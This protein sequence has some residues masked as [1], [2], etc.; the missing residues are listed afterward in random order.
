MSDKVHILLADDDYDQASLLMHYFKLH[1]PGLEFSHARNGGD[2]LRML[3]DGGYSA[4]IL[5]YIMPDM[6][7]TE[8][9][10]KIKSLGYDLPIVMVTGLGDEYVAVEALKAGAYDYVI[11][12]GQY[13]SSLPY[14][15][16]RAIEQ[17]DLKVKAAEAQKLREQLYQ[18]EKMAV[19]GQLVAGVAHELNNPLTAVLGYAQMLLTSDVDPRVKADL[20]KVDDAAQRCKKIVNNLLSFARRHRAETDIADMNEAVRDTV[21]LRSYELKVNNITVEERYF[22][23]LPLVTMDRHQVQQVL[24][25]LIINAEQALQGVPGHGAGKITVDTRLMDGGMVRVSVSDTGPGVVPEDRDR[26]FEPF[27]TTK[28]QGKGTGLG[29][30][31]CKGIVAEHGGNL[32][33]EDNEE[34]GACFIFEMPVNFMKAT[35]YAG[36]AA[37]DAPRRILLVDDEL[38]VL[39]LMADM[40]IDEGYRVDVAHGGE[41]AL[42]RI[43]C[44]SYDL[45]VSDVK[46]P[47]V[48]GRRLYSHI[49]SARPDM[50]AK[51]LFITGDTGAPQTLEFISRLDG[52]YL[53]KPFSADEF[54][55]TCGKYL[56]PAEG[57]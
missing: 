41:E 7:G 43:G 46:M 1:R 39:D 53:L 32:W 48:D 51:L 42:A 30:P 10:G 13:F 11:K 28:E 57:H 47:G 16:D 24:L 21:A 50:A 27:Y 22:E 34:G 44:T 9:I 36:P 37:G 25:N 5:D 33:V 52:R 18:S 4:L 49:Q 31:I 15:V 6:R 17:Y 12:D 3:G 14:A 2:C 45:V 8:V 55:T 56:N 20:K 40:L 38:S 19:V 23:D 54:R 35:A 29:L 26:I